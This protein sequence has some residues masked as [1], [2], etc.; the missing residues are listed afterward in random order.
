[1]A[2]LT[3]F[4]ASVGHSIVAKRGA[5]CPQKPTIWSDLNVFKNK[6]L[7]DLW[8]G[9]AYSNGFSST[10]RLLLRVTKEVVDPDG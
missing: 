8:K 9:A 1:M 5:R 10:T 6:I 3:P 7:S 4:L 2:S